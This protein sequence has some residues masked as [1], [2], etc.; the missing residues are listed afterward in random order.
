MFVVDSQD[1]QAK[2]NKAKDYAFGFA[3]KSGVAASTVMEMLDSNNMSKLKALVNKAEDIAKEYEAQVAEQQNAAQMAIKQEETAAK[4][5]EGQIKIQ[6]ETI[7]SETAIEV[8]L[9]QNS[10]NAE[11]G[12][13]ENNLDN[14]YDDYIE[15]QRSND[16]KK[17]QEGIKSANNTAKTRLDE[18]KLAEAEKKRLSAEKIARQNKNKYDK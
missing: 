10:G 6:V 7:K 17:Q 8:A 2:L 14:N 13:V 1:E 18:A 9:I 5:R 12:E 11:G 16:L 4:E 15:K 3:Q